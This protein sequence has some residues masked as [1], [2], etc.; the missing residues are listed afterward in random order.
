[1]QR[2]RKI[3]E[4][5]KNDYTVC[6]HSSLKNLMT[7]LWP[8]MSTSSLKISLHTKVSDVSQSANDALFQF[9]W[10]FTKIWCKMDFWLQ[11]QI[12]NT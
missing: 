5:N 9:L 8:C 4:G 7:A 11:I 2:D 1:M 10:L 6:I 12:L 3:Y